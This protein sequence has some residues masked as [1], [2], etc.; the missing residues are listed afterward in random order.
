M[1]RSAEQIEDFVPSWDTEEARRSWRR[2]TRLEMIVSGCIG[3]VTSFVLSSEAWQLAADSSTRFGCDVSAV[4]SCSTVAQTWQA[5]ILG[6]P[7]AFLGIFF[8]AVVLAISVG[9]AAGVR[10]PRWYM[11]CTNLLYTVA[12]FFAFWLFSQSYFIIQ[13]LCPWCLL[14]TLTTTLVFGGITRINIRDGVIPA[15]ESVRRI[16]AQG[17]D[18]AL[19]GLIVFGVLAMVVAKY[20]LKLLG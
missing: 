7:N 2:R 16:V 10:F 5:R 15:P 19:W 11:A 6:F 18:W 14:I 17:L 3:L 4:L 9:I 1:T 8:E 12:L 13:V 20:G